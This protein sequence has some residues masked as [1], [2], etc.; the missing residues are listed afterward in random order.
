MAQSLVTGPRYWM[1]V[2]AAAWACGIRRVLL[3]GVRVGVVG[4]EVS[5]VNARA[6]S[7]PAVASIVSSS[8]RCRE[9]MLLM[10]F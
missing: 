4:E 3:E 2:M 6:L 10:L 1:A 7:S 9:I 5:R 8:E